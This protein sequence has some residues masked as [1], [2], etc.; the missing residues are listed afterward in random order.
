MCSRSLFSL[1]RRMLRPS[2]LREAICGSTP[3]V[4][5]G[6]QVGGLRLRACHCLLGALPAAAACRE[7]GGGC[8]PA[9]AARADRSLGTPPAMP[10]MT[11][12]C[13]RRDQ[14][15]TS[16]CQ[17]ARPGGRHTRRTRWWQRGR[18]RC[19]SSPQA[20]GWPRTRCHWRWHS[21]P[22]CGKEG[23]TQLVGLGARPD[24]TCMPMIECGLPWL[25]FPVPAP[26]RHG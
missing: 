22:P 13:R 21:P 14:P 8:S 18:S 1:A 9:Q 15:P 16:P 25:K 19:R 17:A 20:Q 7:A 12:A 26:S 24:R 3:A 4:Q 6:C 5:A 10:C 2:A 23:S 11:D